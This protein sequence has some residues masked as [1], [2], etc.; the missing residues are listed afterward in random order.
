MITGS[1]SKSGMTPTVRSLYSPFIAAGGIR[2]FVRNQNMRDLQER[3]MFDGDPVKRN[4]LSRIFRGRFVKLQYALYGVIA[5]ES[6][7]IK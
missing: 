3:W 4:G 6:A 7:K 1:S 5:R 2:P